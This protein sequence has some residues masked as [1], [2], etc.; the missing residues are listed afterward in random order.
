MDEQGFLQL[1]AENPND[2]DL[3][4][5]YA[6]WLEEHGRPDD[7]LAAR[8][9]RVVKD[10]VE[11]YT[12]AMGASA[13]GYNGRVA[14]KWFGKYPGLR[15]V[16]VGY[17]TITQLGLKYMPPGVPGRPRRTNPAPDDPVSEVL[18]HRKGHGYSINMVAFIDVNG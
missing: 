18:Y 12:R 6:D 7:A 4:L 3:L 15:L 2:P 13:T 16:L 10:N 8:L 1:L 17:Q 5:V 14:R 11:I 9:R